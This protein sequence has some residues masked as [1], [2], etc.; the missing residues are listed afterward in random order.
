MTDRTMQVASGRVTSVSQKT[1]RTKVWS[2]NLGMTTQSIEEIALQLDTVDA[3]LTLRTDGTRNLFIGAGDRL[4]VAYAQGQDQR[5]IYGVRNETDGSVYL[6]R[7]A[8]VVGART[9]AIAILG[10]LVCIPLVIGIM[11]SVERRTDM[12]VEMFAWFGGTAIGL[13]ALSTIL[14]SAFGLIAWPEIR[15][16]R[17]PGGKREMTAASNA[18]SLAP[19]ET[20]HIRFI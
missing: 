20:P 9:D 16:L 18:L 12:I 19:D 8:K 6:V 11:A 7:P 14:R 2:N 3:P 5:A 15:R 10:L 13:F 4:T 17:Q 1:L